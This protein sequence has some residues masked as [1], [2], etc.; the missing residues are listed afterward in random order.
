MKNKAFTLVEM[1]AVVI[2]LAL[3]L[4]I[5]V[6][7]IGAILSNFRHVYYKNLEK[8]LETASINYIN[9]YRSKRPKEN[10]KKIICIKELEKE[11]MID[12]V[13]S[14]KHKNCDIKGDN[15]K[16]SYV[17]VSKKDNKYNY[18][19]CLYCDDDSYSSKCSNSD[20]PQNIDI[21]ELCK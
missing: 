16:K 15:D 20:L 12:K 6:P 18:K 11:K 13:L 2:I 14:Y 4:I 10:D 19:I 8:E 3:L 1:I 7:S 9:T 5:A 17:I 21:D